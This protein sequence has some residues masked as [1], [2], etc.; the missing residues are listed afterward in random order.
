MKLARSRIE[1]MARQ[2]EP[3][4]LDLNQEHDWSEL[5]KGSKDKKSKVNYK[6]NLGLG[7]LQ[8]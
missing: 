6:C 8:K 4:G 1:T 5:K 7:V 3:P 2:I